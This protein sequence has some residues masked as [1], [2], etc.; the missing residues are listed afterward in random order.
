[1]LFRSVLY[2]RRAFHQENT[3]IVGSILAIYGLGLPAFV[4]IKALQPGFYAREDTKTPMRFSGVAVATN[5]A[6]ALSLFP[7]MGA[8]GIA[9]AEAT[10]GWIS[11]VLLFTTLLR[12][13]HLAWEWGLARRAVLLLVSAGVMTGMILYLQH[14]WEPYLASGASLLTKVGT[15]GLL[16][17]ISMLVYFAVA[18]LIG[19]ADLGMIRRNMNRKP[20]ATAPDAETAN[21]E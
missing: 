10:A 15:L 9:V 1:M 21:G 18:F 4:L 19:G 8:P 3:L 17:A 2:E 7:Y 13:G 5:C 14:R 12:R 6:I 11:T 20:P 16:I